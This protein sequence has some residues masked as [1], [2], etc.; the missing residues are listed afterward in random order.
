MGKYEMRKKSLIALL[1]FYN[2]CVTENE[3]ELLETGKYS[4]QYIDS[5]ADRMLG[6]INM[7]SELGLLKS[8]ELGNLYYII[9]DFKNHEYKSSKIERMI[10]Y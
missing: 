7:I 4:V 8:G 6:M 9:D 3:I 10:E 5:C 1:H 2:D